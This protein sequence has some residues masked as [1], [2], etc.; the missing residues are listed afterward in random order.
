MPAT[1]SGATYPRFDL[2]LPARSSRLGFPAVEFHAD[3]ASPKR[4]ALDFQAEAL[5]CAFSPRKGD[6]APG[7]DDAVPRKMIASPES[8]D[9][10]PSRSRESCGTGHLAVGDDPPSRDPRDHGAE[11]G[12]R[13]CFARSC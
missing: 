12:E 2:H 4:H 6:P 9:G 1:T 3:S 10:E 13:A 7:A 11:G 8:S 5:L